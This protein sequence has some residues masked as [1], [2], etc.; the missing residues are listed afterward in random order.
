MS[1]GSKGPLQADS[2]RTDG[3]AARVDFPAI[4]VLMA[5]LAAQVLAHRLPVVPVLEEAARVLVLPATVVAQAT[6]ALAVD[7]L[8]RIREVLLVAPAALLD[9]AFI[10]SP[11]FTASP[12]KSF[13]LVSFARMS[14]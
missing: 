12:L 7:H 2:L 11:H 1:A 14:E 5:V 4:P 6:A 3:Q 10:A 8:A 9:P 13:V